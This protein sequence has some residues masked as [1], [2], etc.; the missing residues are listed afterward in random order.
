MRIDAEL[1]TLDIIAQKLTCSLG[2]PLRLNYLDC[3]YLCIHQL[4]L[5]SNLC[6]FECLPFTI[7]L[8]GS[9]STSLSFQLLMAPLKCAKL[10]TLSLVLEFQLFVSKIGSLQFSGEFVLVIFVY[11]VSIFEACLFFLQCFQLS[12]CGLVLLERFGK[13]I[14]VAL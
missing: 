14:E 3:F 4:T 13:L 9:Q 10:S 11:F 5:N 12:C 7:I 8:L 6:S 1:I 2:C